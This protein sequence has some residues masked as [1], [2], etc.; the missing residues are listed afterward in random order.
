V[1]LTAV[2]RIAVPIVASGLVLLASPD[3]AAAHARLESSVPSSGAELD[4]APS[5]VVLDFS[6]SVQ[7]GL[8]EVTLSLA[9][10]TPIEIGE[11]TQPD[12]SSDIVTASLPALDDGVYVLSYRVISADGHPISGDIV[13]RIGAG[14][15]TP[16]IESSNR[17]SGLVGF[18]YGLVRALAYISLT[19]GLGLAC[20]VATIWRRGWSRV[21]FTI[22]IAGWVLAAATLAQFL[23][24]GPY[25]AGTGVGDILEPTRWTQVADT[26]AG[27]W[28]LVRFAALAGLALVGIVATSL[29]PS[30]GRWRVRT[31]TI[32]GALGAAVVVASFVGDGHASA[33]RFLAV[34][35]I[36]TGIHI[37][38]MA[39]WLGGLGVLA[40]G[41]VADDPDLVRGVLRRWSVVAA[42][43]VAALII[44]GTAQSWRLLDGWSA[45]DSTFGRLLIAK[46][47]AL[48][49][50]VVLGNFGRMRLV[51]ARR[52]AEPRSLPSTLRAGVL[53][54]LAIGVGV[55][56]L[57]TVLVQSEPASSVSAAVPTAVTTTSAAATPEWRTEIVQG[58]WTLAVTLDQA[59]VGRRHLVISLDDT[60]AP[61]GDPIEL[62]ARL[63]L[64]AEG[65]ESVPVALQAT[66]PR[67]WSTNGVEL[68]NPGTWSLE[69]LVDDPAT[70]ARFATSIPIDALGQ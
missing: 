58:S 13:F 3:V 27:K 49:G 50:M 57:T 23:L 33:G 36:A 9:D 39:T 30:P 59:V 10:S 21:R 26:A 16:I 24:A 62:R 40:W 14:S 48:V 22:A 61:F 69:V 64:A 35:L 6:E 19:V 4:E 67:T 68:P 25:L 51:N 20:A 45:L 29:S 54:E 41:R 5:E 34:G 7:L 38:A 60:A 52:A 56:F 70:T 37:V 43:S 55:L 28:W 63:S 8:G 17:P 15:G 31:A 1:R 47:I 65:I 11:A 53:A 32:A 12:G 18:V 46:T 66:G 44:T 2:C 42:T